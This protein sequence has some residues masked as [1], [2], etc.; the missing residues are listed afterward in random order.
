MDVI[1]KFCGAKKWKNETASLCCNSGKVELTPYPSPPV[2]IKN[3]LTENS[4]EAKLFRENSR[5]FNNALAL[6]SIRVNE[7]KFSNGYNPSVIFEGKVQQLYGPLLPENGEDP[8]FAQLYIHDPST[9]HTIR[10]KNMC[11]PDSLSKQHVDIITK[12]LQKLQS[13]IKEV[14][15]FVKDFL[16]ICEVPD[17]AIKDGK[18][19]I[20][21]RR[22]TKRRA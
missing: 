10:V 11:L 16:H 13:L 8:K 7:K 21:C 14:N 19:I 15:P 18:L 9:Q 12:T 6:S 4:T 20:S 22:Q 17:S 5:S 1:C 3:L 2:F